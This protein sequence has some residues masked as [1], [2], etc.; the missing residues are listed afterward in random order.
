MELIIQLA[1]HGLVHGDFNEFNLMIDDDEK[2]TMIDF[3]QMT[4]TS[5]QDAKFYFERDV[6]CVQTYFNRNYGMVFSGMPEL[7]DDITRLVDL[8]TEIKA[9]GFVQEALGKHGDVS[10]FDT[11][12]EQFLAEKPAESDGEAE[13]S[14]SEDEDQK[15]ASDAGESDADK[16][17][18]SDK[19]SD[20][21][22]DSDEE[23]KIPSNDNRRV[24][25][26]ETF[27]QREEQKK[28][29]GEDEDEDKP[30]AYI[31]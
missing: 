12:A 16:K 10:V 31:D 25:F 17:S 20:K 27:A 8:D 19:E 23:E 14:G 9:S 3:P 11:V 29:E 1:E 7:V 13:S 18:Q 6:K 15:K 22:S 26:A 21:E 24:R 4:S 28:I 2:I 5:H 30:K